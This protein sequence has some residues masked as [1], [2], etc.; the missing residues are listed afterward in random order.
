MFRSWCPTRAVAEKPHTAQ[1]VLKEGQ[2]FSGD[3]ASTKAELE[4]SYNS[5][6]Q[7]YLTEEEAVEG[8]IQRHPFPTRSKYNKCCHLVS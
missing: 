4:D 6:D 2:N 8:G 5:S 3:H 1:G 7:L